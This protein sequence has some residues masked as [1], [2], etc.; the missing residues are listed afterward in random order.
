MRGN[1]GFMTIPQKVMRRWLLFVSTGSSSLAP[2][3]ATTSSALSCLRLL[4]QLAS[5]LSSPRYAKAFARRTKKDWAHT[6]K[7]L[8]DEQYP[9]AQ[10]VVLVMD[11]LNTHTLCSLYE[12]FPKD[13]AFRIAQRLEIHYTP[14]HSSHLNIAEIELSAMATQCLGHRRIPDI[15]TLNGELAAWHSMRNSFQKGVDWHF[16]STDAPIKLNRLYPLI[17]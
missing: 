2:V 11:N 4:Y 12:P 6:I 10:T 14:N 7:S 16:T 9:F 3:L 8:V 13:E 5:P 1:D 17:L 15:Q